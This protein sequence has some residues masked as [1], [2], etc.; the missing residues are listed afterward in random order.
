MKLVTGLRPPTSGTIDVGRAAD[1]PAVEDRP[2]WRFRTRPLLPGRRTLSNV[3][4]PMENRRTAIATA[5]AADRKQHE[6]RHWRC[7]IR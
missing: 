2:V 7:W 1:R 3:M 4:L 6:A 5:S